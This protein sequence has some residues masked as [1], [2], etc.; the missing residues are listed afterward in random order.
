MGDVLTE[1][2]GVEVVIEEWMIVVNRLLVFVLALQSMRVR[3]F[4]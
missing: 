2:F 4:A 1:L 3:E